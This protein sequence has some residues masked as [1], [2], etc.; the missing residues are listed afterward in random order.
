DHQVALQSNLPC[1]R[2]HIQ[3][4]T[5]D[6][7]VPKEN[8]YKCHFEK[9]R[10][11]RYHETDLMHST[12]LTAHKIECNQCHLEIQHK[13]I[14]DIEIMAD[15]RTCHLNYHEPQKILF[16]G[17]GGQGV[18]H[19]LPSIK[20]IK[21]L[22]CQGCHVLHQEARKTEGAGETL[23][24]SGQSCETCHG[25]GFSRLLNQWKNSTAREISQIRQVLIRA[26]EEL[27]KASSSQKKEAERLIKEALFNLELVDKGK[28]VHN[29][30]YSL[31]LLRASLS[32]I[33]EAMN[34]I[35]SDYEPP[36]TT[37]LTDRIPSTCANCHQGVDSI[38][39]KLWGLFF[40]HKS[41][42]EK[43]DLNCQACHLLTPK[44]G[45]LI[46]TK[47]F[48]ASCHHES[49]TQECASCHQL[50]ATVYKGGE[51]YNLKIKADSMAE[52]GVNCHDCHRL[53][54]G[55]IQRL[56]SMSCLNCHEENYLILFNEK[57]KEIKLKINN[58]KSLLNEL[59]KISLDEGSKKALEN[60]LKIL[61]ELDH[62]GSGGAHNL[63]FYDNWLSDRLTH[64]TSRHSTK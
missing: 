31:E 38:K 28:A 53:E 61:N 1:Q 15:C 10:L 13:I 25:Q 7:P 21:G 47:K 51:L 50:Q 46:A 59:K 30:N 56:D 14:K 34:L 60:D 16:S 64:W 22:S 49:A 35:G 55:Q 42:L 19:P 23:L 54:K 32:L 2:C 63:S 52:A 41:H 3:V 33:A 5:G 20:M 4:I 18:S 12:H 6:G 48:C 57:Q 36:K 39:V 37:A 17:Q 58:L 26:Q 27:K 11:E 62:E 40:D 43:T 29:M 9:D 8:C 24:A 45:T 44:H